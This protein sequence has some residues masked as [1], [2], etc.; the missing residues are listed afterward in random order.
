MFVLYARDSLTSSSLFCESFIIVTI[1]IEGFLATVC[2]TSIY[3]SF[4]SSSNILGGVK[5][6]KAIACL[7]SIFSSFDNL[8]NTFFIH[9]ISF[10]F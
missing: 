9:T 7:I 5:V 4:D 1:E 6:L 3:L 10:V 2:L 8:S